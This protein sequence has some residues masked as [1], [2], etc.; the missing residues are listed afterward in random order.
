MFLATIA[1]GQ[2]RLGPDIS[3]PRALTKIIPSYSETARDL[4]IEGKVIIQAIVRKDGAVEVIGVKQGLGYGLDENAVLALRRLKL[5]PATKNG[6]PVDVEMDIAVDFSLDDPNFA[7]PR[8]E[9]PPVKRFCERRT[10][11]TPVSRV[12]PQ[13]TD[14]ARAAGITGTVI[15]DTMVQTD[16]HVDVIRVRKS[17]GFGLDSAAIAAISK[18]VFRPATC[19]GAPEDTM[20]TVDMNFSSK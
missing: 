4:R 3:P 5:S 10:N 18:W 12:Q 14:A 1:G 20:L 11:P 15:L 2:Q 19:D 13:L 6:I 9:R 16:G 7:E 17:L 8:N